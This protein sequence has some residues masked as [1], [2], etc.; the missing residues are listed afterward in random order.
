MA[1]SQFKPKCVWLQIACPVYRTTVAL[2]EI[3]FGVAA[4]SI[5]GNYVEEK[6]L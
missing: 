2:T 4:A 5:E 6:I 3:H 1:E